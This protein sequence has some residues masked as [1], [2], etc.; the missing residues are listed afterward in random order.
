M[1]QRAGFIGFIILWCVVGGL[2]CGSDNDDAE[3]AE[4]L[5]FDVV[6]SLLEAEFTV[7]G[8]NKSIRPPKGFEPVADSLHDELQTYFASTMGN[9]A[10]VNFDRFF[11]N[12]EYESGLVVLSIDD[13]N[14][15]S[16]TGFFFN[17]YFQMLGESYKR[18]QIKHG[19]YWVNGIFVKNFLLVDS[20]SV[21]FHLLCLSG[22]DDALE[23]N[24]I[25]PRSYYEDLVKRFES[26]IGSLKPQ[27]GGM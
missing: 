10:R 21:R 2:Y 22:E 7:A 17:S 25:A 1:Y 14:L 19:E 8:T 12:P 9:E 26:S 23:L 15:E 5:T 6:D 13:L 3:Q 4:E 11:Y 16:D 18:D 20:M 24:Y 27:Q